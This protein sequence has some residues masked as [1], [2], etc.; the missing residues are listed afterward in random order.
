MK[1][2]PLASL[3]AQALT[4]EALAVESVAGL[5]EELAALGFTAQ[6]LAAMRQAAQEAEEPWPFPVPLDVR[7]EVGFARF[8]AALAEARQ[9]L[10]LTGL[11]SARPAERPL[12]RDE[13]RLVADRPPHW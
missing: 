8:D 6:R 4:G 9:A 10:G 5:P 7:R 1:A 12:D 13:Q 2:D 3:L 11:V